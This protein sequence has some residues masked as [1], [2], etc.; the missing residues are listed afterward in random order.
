[1]VAYLLIPHT[2]DRLFVA[3]LLWLRLCRVRLFKDKT[4]KINLLL[5]LVFS[6]ALLGAGCACTTHVREVTAKNE[7][8][9]ALKLGLQFK[10]KMIAD[11]LDRLSLKDQEIGKIGDE[12]SIARSAIDDLKGDIEKLR[13][14]DVQMEQKKEEVLREEAIPENTQPTPETDEISSDEQKIE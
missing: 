5:P 14:V 10:E 2:S 7:E 9:A 8:I 11:L 12:L 13:E 1:M 6:G 3:N 4:M